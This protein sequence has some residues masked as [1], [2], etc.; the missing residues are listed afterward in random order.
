M[1]INEVTEV[2]DTGII[3]PDVK[4]LGELFSRNGFEIRVVGGAVRDVALGKSPKD[5]DLATDATP[6]EMQKMFDRAMI[7]HIPTGIEHGTLTA[8]LNNEPYEITTL[9]ADT[10]TD[11]RH[12]EVKFVKS[13]EEDAKRRDLTYNAMSMDLSGEIHDYFGGMD[14]LQNK[15]SKFVGNPVDRIQE[16]F[17]RILRYFRFQGRLATPTW[18]K[19]TLQAVADNAT[20][21]SKISVERVWMEV[22]KILSGSNVA[23][24]V[25][26]MTKTGVSKTIGLVTNDLNKVVD[27]GNP[28]IALAQLGNNADIS[29]RWNM[30]KPEMILLAFLAENKNNVLDK[31][32]VEDMIADGI[33]KEKISALAELQGQ[34]KMADH[35]MI[36]SVPDFPVTGADLIAMGV[37]PGPDMGK[38]L[39][40]LKQQW[41]ASNFKATKDQLLGTT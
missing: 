25:Q 2:Q 23:G 10:E 19:E 28:I 11:G 20:G 31:K 12:A 6:Q 39:N 15:V 34:K 24:I 1:K 40:T 8:V 26:Q 22:S 35:A 38:Q 7:K 41:K 27:G 33:D 14:D 4:T 13:W 5:I 21:L 17:L 30:S 9:R 36:T 29:K 18:D 37:K 3:S 16:D 32:K